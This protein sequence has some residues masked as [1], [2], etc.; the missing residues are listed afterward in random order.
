MSLRSRGLGDAEMRLVLRFPRPDVKV[1]GLTAETPGVRPINPIV[2]LTSAPIALTAASSRAARN[3]SAN[4][5]ALAVVQPSLVDAMQ[6]LPAHGEWVLARDGSLTLLDSAGAWI[7]NC[8]LPYRAGVAMLK[9]LDPRGT[10]ACFLA[11]NHAAEIRA[12][13]ERL[14]PEQAVLTIQPDLQSLRIALACEDFSAD[15][16]AHR[17]FFA[18]GVNCS[19]EMRSI[20]ATNPGLPTPQ[21]FIK[22]PTLSSELV[23]PLIAESQKLFAAVISDRAE[24][25]RATREHRP[26][27]PR[28]VRQIAVIAGSRFSLWDDAGAARAEALL[29]ASLDIERTSVELTR[30][31]P[32]LPIFAGPLATAELCKDCDAL[33]TPDT[34]RCDFPDVLPID[35]P[36]V[37][38]VTK[39]R[40]PA[41]QAAGPNDALL[42][43][44]AAWLQAAVSAG[45][46]PERVGI[47]TFA[48][49]PITSTVEQ[50]FDGWT[51][52]AN[53][54]P[55]SLPEKL[56]EFSSH[57]LLWE[58]IAAEL[59]ADPFAVG[60]DV[61][62]YLYKLSRRAGIDEASMDRR[63]FIESLILPAYQQGIVRA[64]VNAK[65]PVRL[66]GAGWDVIEEFQSLAGGPIASRASLA[67]ALASSSK[68][69][70]VWPTTQAHLIDSAGVP[71][72]RRKLS[73]LDAFIR[74][75]KQ[76]QPPKSAP[77]PTQPMSV[78]RILSV[79]PSDF[80]RPGRERRLY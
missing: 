1:G 80:G 40:I 53:T 68:L 52:I 28:E 50:M 26:E 64:T 59:T 49:R 12:A 45:W 17:L 29:P 72:F 47:A 79:L 5:R 10:V 73:R 39:G 75:A 78:D 77:Q 56:E 18:F 62:P 69:V 23:D 25:V 37:T 32:D 20:F 67:S 16:D 24:R 55:I 60:D 3:W 8:S 19:E 2:T 57:R 51:V 44:D 42:V 71:V 41:A 14:S 21:Q 35:L 70:H 30:L 43:A 7:G 38:W 36:W 15:L 9:T 74:E 54:V 61:G 66:F 34:G 46:K 22:L 27:S 63:L 13:L 48:P 58:Q 11:P 4:L 65:L 33:I 31:D 76:Y 6:S